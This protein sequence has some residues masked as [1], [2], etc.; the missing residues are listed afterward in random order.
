MI[1][2]FFL[3]MVASSENKFTLQTKDCAFLR[4]QCLSDASGCEHAWRK[5][6]DSCNA[7]GDPCKISN[8]SHCNLSIQSLVE[9]NSQ[10]EECVC[11]DDF[12]CT[13]N[14]FLGKKCV[15][16][17]DNVKD[18][19]KLKWNLTTPF[20]YGFKG[21]WSCL[22]VTEACVGDAFCNA[23]LAPYLK[24]CSTIENLCDVKHCQTA[25]RFF[26]QNMPF[27]IAQMLAFCDCAQSDIPCQ[28]SKEALHS[29]LCAV[30]VAP[31]PTCLGVIHSCQNDELCRRRFRAFQS[32]CW[33][34]VAGKCH[35]D[36]TCISMLSEQDFTCAGSDD[37][38]AAYLGILGTALQVPCT[39]RTTTQSEESLCKTL[40]HMLQRKSCF[41][42]P[43]LSDVKGMAL[44]K[45]EHEKELTLAGFPS[46][47]SGEVI[48]AILGMAVTC[49]ILFLVMLSLRISRLLSEERNP[50]AIQIPGAVIVH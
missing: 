18:Y 28:Q 4:K 33:P 10:F 11:T 50:P 2:L 45:G 36:E 21:I 15:N 23:Q 6:E 39:C 49:G 8:S 26:Y 46:P 3:A 19:N 48:Y 20:H 22:E 29:K 34:R 16:K 38:K 35:E 27:N 25:I 30:N 14:N 47:F 24:A 17:S 31:P 1:V 40:Q 41:N 44:Y 7:S 13:V 9:S 42:Y 5:M 32:K 12:D 37:C 43:T